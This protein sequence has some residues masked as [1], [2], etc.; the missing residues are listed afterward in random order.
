MGPETWARPGSSATFVRNL[1]GNKRA[2]LSANSALTAFGLPLNAT[3]ATPRTIGANLSF[4][5]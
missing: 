2:I 3:V 1:I 4:N 5:F